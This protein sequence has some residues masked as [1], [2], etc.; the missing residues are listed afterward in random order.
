MRAE[1]HA[2]DL[3]VHAGW[4]IVARNWRF[5]HKEVDLIARRGRLVAFVEVKCRSG[6]R[7]GSPAEAVTRAKRRD[8]AC[9]AAGWIA[10][11]ARPG[12]EFRFD[13]IAVTGRAE[14]P[15]LAHFED[16]WRL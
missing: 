9:A 15:S 1:R 16:A 14:R 13:L 5:G 3:L 7:Y 12:D 6:P 10:R 4:D 8:L 11:H 2:A